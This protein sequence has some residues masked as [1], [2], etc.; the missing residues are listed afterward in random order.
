MTCGVVRGS[1][2]LG[3]ELVE[4]EDTNTFVTVAR[5]D[6]APKGVSL[7]EIKHLSVRVKDVTTRCTPATVALV[8][9]SGTTGSGVIV[10]EDG[11]IF[12]AAHVVQGETEMTVVFPDGTTEKAKVLGA[13][14]T[15]D[16]AMA[17][18]TGD[19]KYPYVKVGDSDHLAVGTYVVALGHAKGFDPNR[20]APVR[21]GRLVADGKQRFMMSE[22]TL[23]G[24]D[25]GGP[26]FNLKGEL[27]GIHSSIGPHVMINNH[28]PIE[29]FHKNREQ[30]LAGSHWGELAMHPMA[31]PDMPVLG[32][33]M[34]E[35]RNVDGVVVMGVM[36]G[37]PADRAGLQS[38]DLVLELGGRPVRNAQE[39]I[40]ELE[41]HKAGESMDIKIV[42]EGKELRKTVIPMRRGDLSEI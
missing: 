28:V 38:R 42:R 22:C 39:L 36:R 40:R 10:S 29:V 19:R 12:T 15:R 24:G 7:E 31:D 11:L 20:R 34:G 13:Y 16:A 37:S 35:A 1:E 32:F 9:S 3:A 4:G 23:I 21:F 6:D 8:G 27:V 18:L 5:D 26:L 33:A 25:S 41:R 30:L 2:A 17:K 14:Y